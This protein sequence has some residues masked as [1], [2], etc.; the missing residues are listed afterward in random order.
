MCLKIFPCTGKESREE[1]QALKAAL[2]LCQGPKTSSGETDKYNYSSPPQG[3]CCRL[4]QVLNLIYGNVQLLYIAPQLPGAGSPVGGIIS[5]DP[6]G[7]EGL[8]VT[9]PTGIKP[10]G[11][12]AGGLNTSICSSWPSLPMP[13][14]DLAGCQD[15]VAVP[16]VLPCGLQWTALDQQESL[17]PGSR[18]LRV[19]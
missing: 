7:D 4:L 14:A 3:P 15:V 10:T 2:F 1:A 5:K 18:K 12:K 13:G 16:S 8:W 19:A 11:C 17:C 9:D 6:L